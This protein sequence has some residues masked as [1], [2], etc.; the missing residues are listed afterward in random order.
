MSYIAAPL[1]PWTLLFAVFVLTIMA[2]RPNIMLSY[3]ACTVLPF[4]GFLNFFGLCLAPFKRNED[5][6]SLLFAVVHA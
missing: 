5:A 4:Q 3:F 6:G 1:V 2:G